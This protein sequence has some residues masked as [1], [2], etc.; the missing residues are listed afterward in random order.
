MGE[1]VLHLAAT[2]PE[3]SRCAPA[4]M[5]ANAPLQFLLPANVAAMKRHTPF[6]ACCGAQRDDASPQVDGAGATEASIGAGEYKPAAASRAGTLPTS[7]RHSMRPRRARSFAHTPRRP[8]LVQRAASEQMSL[9]TFCC[10]TTTRWRRSTTRRQEA[11]SST[12]PTKKAWPRHRRS[13]S[14]PSPKKTKKPRQATEA[15][16]SSRVMLLPTSLPK[17]NSERRP[18][19]ARPSH[20][21]VSRV[22]SE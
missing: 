5:N 9:P 6:A 18:S 4:A 15:T 20:C 8:R 1:A 17:K 22:Q 11:Y 2:R 21:D 19:N 12:C 16:S 10:P 3:N 13:G 7:P 14:T